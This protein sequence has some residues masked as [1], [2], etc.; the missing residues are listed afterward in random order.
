MDSKVSG[1][2]KRNKTAGAYSGIPGHDMGISAARLQ[3]APKSGFIGGQP[4]VAALRARSR[5]VPEPR[6][7]M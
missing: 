3:I 6:R 5:R 4:R 1:T 7:Y 2:K